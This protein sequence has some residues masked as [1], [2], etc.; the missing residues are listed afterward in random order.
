M[1]ENHFIPTNSLVAALLGF[2]TLKFM[3]VINAHG[4]VN[5][6]ILM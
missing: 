4:K 5:N 6:K 1:H 3:K 2:S